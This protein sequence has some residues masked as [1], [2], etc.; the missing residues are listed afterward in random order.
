MPYLLTTPTKASAGWR[1]GI[2]YGFIRKFKYASKIRRREQR[3]CYFSSSNSEI[4]GM[5]VYC[6]TK[7]PR[8]IA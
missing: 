7:P 1:K 6:S 4:I 2:F 5:N 3:C 8:N